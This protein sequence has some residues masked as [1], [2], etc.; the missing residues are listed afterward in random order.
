MVE[1]NKN[2]GGM[3]LILWSLALMG[4]VGLSLY[5]TW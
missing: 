5:I 4:L 1:N 3:P 2:T